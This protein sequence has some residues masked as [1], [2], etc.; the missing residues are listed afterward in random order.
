MKG[1]ALTDVKLQPATKYTLVAVTCLNKKANNIMI[2]KAYR[3]NL[4]TQFNCTAG[5]GIFVI[6]KTVKRRAC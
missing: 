2:F 4:V 6:P 5:D 3:S 1:L